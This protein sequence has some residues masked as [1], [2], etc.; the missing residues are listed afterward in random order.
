MPALLV[1]FV[2]TAMLRWDSILALG[3]V[4]SVAMLAY[5][6]SSRLRTA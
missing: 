6:P 2:A 1:T 4:A 3:I 5:Q